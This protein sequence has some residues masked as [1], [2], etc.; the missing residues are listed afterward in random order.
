MKVNIIHSQHSNNI[1]CDAEVMNYMLKRVKEKPKISHINVNNYTCPKA[2]INIFIES[3]NYS[4]IRKAKYNVFIPNHQYFSK[5]NIP[6][7]E[8]IDLVFCKTKYC[9]EVFKDLVE[10]ERIKN[11][12]W[13]ST[14][15]SNHRLDKTREDWLALYNDHNYQDIQK[16]IDI[17]QLDYPTLNIVFSGV[18]KTGLTKRNLANIM[19]I[20][21]IEP[22]KYENLFNSCLIHVCLD[23]IDNFNHNVNQ[24]MLSGNVPICINKG[25]IT[26]LLYEDNYFALTCSKKKNPNFLGS[27]YTFSKETL[28][29]TVKKALNISD[30]SLE[31]MGENNKMWACRQQNIFN[32]RAQDYFQEVF[33]NTLAVKKR[34]DKEHKDEDL[35][36]ISLITVYS[37]TMNFFKLPI[38]N[39]RSHSYPREKLEWV[40]INN[41]DD[42]VE[43]M[44]P[45]VEV[46]E[47][48]RI[49]YVKANEDATHGHMLNLGIENATNDTI[50]IMDDDYFFYETGL[51]KV[52]NEYLNSKK[53]V[54]GCT[55]M[56]TFDINR[57]ISI[58]STNGQSIDYFQRI[59]LGTMMFSK[60][61]WENGKF[62]TDIGNETQGLLRGRFREYSE[63]SWEDK[64]VGLIYS[65]N[66]KKWIVPDNQAPNGCHYKF[67]KKVYEFIVGLDPKEKVSEEE[68]NYDVVDEASEVKTI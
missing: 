4:F 3:I 50:M 58:I 42:D 34:E 67:S 47:Q 6:M 1:M 28:E 46:R 45:P 48:F 23:T 17:W 27:K 5:E 66:E 68:T 52:A 12:G 55:T 36:S 24:C 25:P 31:L 59:Y 9:Y 32:E 35:P 62:S 39:F 11:I 22:G 33:R 13:R 54:I 56:G 26:E 49:R 14:D 43:S 8:S 20:E 16:L 10:P 29:E 63:Y 51:R 38:L 53:E 18:P 44:L 30:S 21:T 64:Y 2:Q 57:Y 61:F 41:T 60:K 40:V 37:S 7:L 15:I 19:Y 65:N